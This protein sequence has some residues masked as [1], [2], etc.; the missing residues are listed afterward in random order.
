M[1]QALTAVYRASFVGQHACSA[2]LAF[3]RGLKTYN[4]VVVEVAVFSPV[5]LPGHEH[6]PVV[7]AVFVFIGRGQGIGDAGCVASFDCG[8][9]PLLKRASTRV[10]A[11]SSTGL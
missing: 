4:G 9:F 5:P 11:L 2:P 6:A 10:C 3:T 7:T 1:T 8:Q